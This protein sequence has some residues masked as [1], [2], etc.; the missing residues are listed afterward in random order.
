MNNAASRYGIV[1]L[2]NVSQNNI[3]YIDL[4][5]PLKEAI[6]EQQ[7]KMAARMIAEIIRNSDRETGPQKGWCR[8]CR[9]STC[10]ACIHRDSQG[11]RRDFGGRQNLTQF[12]TAVPFIGERG[13]GKTSV[14]YSVWERLR[15]YDGNNENAAFYLGSDLKQVHFVTLDMIDAGMLKT[16]EDVLEI[17]LAQMLGYLEGLRDDNAFLDLYRRIDELHINLCAVKDDREREEY[18]LTSLQ[19]VADSRGT[20]TKF[21]EL[22]QE[23]LLTIGKNQFGGEKCYLVVALDDIDMYQGSNGGMQ[24]TQFALLEHIYRHLRIPGLIVLMTY[25]E[26]LLKRACHH[27]FE[28]IYFGQRVTRAYDAIEQQDINELTAQ[29]MSKLFPQEKRIYMPNFVLVDAVDRPN[30]YVRPVWEN[31]CLKPFEAGEDML[32]VKEFMLRLIAYKTDVYFDAAGTKKHFFEPR[33][34]RELGELFSFVNSMENIPEE[35]DKDPEAVKSRNRQR[36]LDYL[37]NQ[38]ALRHMNAKEYEE[39]TE[40][41]R[42]PLWRQDR[43]LIDKIRQQR[44][45]IA[46]KPGEF[47]YLSGPGEDRWRYSYGELLH[48]IYF[49]TRISKEPGGENPYFRKEF[50]H[51]IFGTQSV[52]MNEAIRSAQLRQDMLKVVGSSIAGR[53]ANR[54]LPK[55]FVP[56]Y[57][58]PAGAGSISLPVRDYF[59]WRIPVGVHKAILGLYQAGDKPDEMAAK[60]LKA[61]K[62]D[63]EKREKEYLKNFVEALVISGMFFTNIPS[64]GLGIR[65]DVTTDENG[66]AV[67]CLRS[68]STE[69]I[70]FNVFN[71]VI[72]LYDALP[73]KPNEKSGYLYNMEQKLLRLGRDFAAQMREDWDGKCIEADAIIK[74]LDTEERRNSLL[75]LIPDSR[76]RLEKKL[77]DAKSKKAYAELWKSIQGS[78]GFEEDLFLKIWKNAVTSVISR[79]RLST[80]SWR[81]KHAGSYWVLPVQNF[82]MMYNINKRLANVSYH[83]IA[84]D[85]DASDVFTHYRSLYNSLAEELEKQDN[86]YCT[87]KEKGFCQAFKS[88]C[89]YGAV[90]ASPL[91]ASGK[92]NGDYNPFI[93]DV[94]V[95]I[96]SSTVRANATR[97][98]VGEIYL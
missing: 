82:D 71:F 60:Q 4:G 50:M 96:V 16:T 13:T 37:K 63:A 94:L 74:E 90:T 79:Y 80:G 67:L 14:M 10:N 65:L 89:F 1:D 83:D 66:K 35:S 3:V 84:D 59:N 43:T 22:V 28:E 5:K 26:Y 98:R 73:E 62:A 45:K 76:D 95:S 64:R 41:L 87:D 75:F 53:W 40:L 46:A 68:D 48:N 39:F 54:M 36:L 25:N 70:C 15:S 6:F 34:L 17:I 93:E 81:R 57:A 72:N 86:V 92:L 18:G 21:M 61:T 52:Q 55:L 56:D 20:V 38:Y 42:L 27:H 23:F 91:T 69:H 2:I 7:Y 12:H 44:Q 31:K 58:E 33:N 8:E 9:R 78:A 30:L 29:F 11:Y 97:K 77:K 32:P 51:C 49:S 24:N 85:A 47:G 19:H 88:C